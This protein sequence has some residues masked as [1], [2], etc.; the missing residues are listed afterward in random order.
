MKP[1]IR[2]TKKTATSLQKYGVLAPTSAYEDVNRRLIPAFCSEVSLLGNLMLN[3]IRRFPFLVGSF[4]IGIP[5]PL[6]TSSYVGPTMLLMGI[7]R[8]RP[9]SVV[10][11]AV[12]PVRASTREIFRVA[13]RSLPSLLNTLWG[14]SSMIKTKSEGMTPRC[15]F[16]FSGKVIFVPFFQ[17]GL[18][19]IVRISSVVVGLL[20]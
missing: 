15:S 8:F 1:G 7:V 19:S 14:F 18:I 13:I 16:P 5:S 10:T 3:L 11:C 2:Q 4:G 17:P 6:T 20:P 12:Y 9:S